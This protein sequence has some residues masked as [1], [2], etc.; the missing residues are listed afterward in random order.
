MQILLSLKREADQWASWKFY[1]IQTLH[2]K[3]MWY[4]LKHDTK[5]TQNIIIDAAKTYEK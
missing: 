1:A 3:E 4:I 5:I 2:S